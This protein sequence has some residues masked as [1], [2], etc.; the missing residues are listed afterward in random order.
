MQVGISEDGF[1]QIT[2][3]KHRA[4]EM[5]FAEVCPAQ[6]CELKMNKGEVPLAE[7]QSPQI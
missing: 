6:S 5:G 7:N 1:S 3:D 2:R 4:A